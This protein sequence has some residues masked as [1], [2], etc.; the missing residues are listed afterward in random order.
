MGS[1]NLIMELEGVP[2]KVVSTLK[3]LWVFRSHG[4]SDRALHDVS[5][6][7]RSHLLVCLPSTVGIYASSE[8]TE[9]LTVKSAVRCAVDSYPVNGAAELELLD[10]AATYIVVATF[11][12]I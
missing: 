10:T 2:S 1:S 11:R 4:H 6:Q 5:R 12:A 9:K 7:Q 8:N 3:E